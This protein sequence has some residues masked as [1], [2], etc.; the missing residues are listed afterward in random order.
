MTIIAEDLAV[1]LLDPHTGRRLVDGTAFDRALAGAM[2]LDLALAGALV[3]DSAGARARLIPSGPAT[4]DPL[5]EGARARLTP[6]P[7]KAQRAVERLARGSWKRVIERLEADGAV[8]RASSRVL[9]I[10]PTTTWTLTGSSRR[11]ALLTGVTAALRGRADPDQRTA[12]LIS[13]VHA[14]KAEHKLVDGP[15]KELRARAQAI[16]QSDFA[17]PAVRKAVEAVHAAAIAAIVAANVSVS[18]S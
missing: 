18:G 12:C 3:P 16:S 1:L 9:G 7:Y 2:L 13:L 11:P 10:F 15:R 6:G 17:G 4:A 14:V 8:E 5:L